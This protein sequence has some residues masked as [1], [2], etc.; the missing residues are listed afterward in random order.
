MLDPVD[1]K[2]FEA[3][4]AE[5]AARMGA[6]SAC[7][8]AARTALATGRPQDLRAARQAVDGLEPDIRDPL[9]RAVHRRLATD[10][11]AIWDRMRGADPGG[12]PN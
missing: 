4:A 7:E 8:Q 11:S 2:F 12:R 6:G 5:S 9:L 3:L 10:L 1:R